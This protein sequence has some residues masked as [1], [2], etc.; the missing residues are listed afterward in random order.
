[1]LEE[2][3]ELGIVWGRLHQSVSAIHPVMHS[4]LEEEGV[5][6]ETQRKGWI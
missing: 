5:S 2:E 1:M 6:G 3:G 4:K